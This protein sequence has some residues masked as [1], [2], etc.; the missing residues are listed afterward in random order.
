MS[1]CPAR[2][3]ELGAINGRIMSAEAYAALAEL[4]DDNAQ[5]LDQDVRPRVR[6]GVAISSRE[7]LVALAE[8]ERMKASLNAAIE[9]VERAADADR[10]DARPAGSV[11]RPEH[12]AAVLRAGST[13]SISGGGAER[14]HCRWIAHLAADHLPC[15][16]RTAGVAHRLC[17]SARMTGT[18]GFRQWRRRQN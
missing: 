3:A 15:V 4:A 16:C 17:L 8:R 1:C 11:D 18:C 5:P 9:G 14:V 10:T 7:Y 6:A 12:D 13:S 2:F